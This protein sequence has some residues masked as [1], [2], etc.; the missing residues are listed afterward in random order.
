MKKLFVIWKRNVPLKGRNII[1]R[2]NQG[3][4]KT[5]KIVKITVHSW[6]KNKNY[7]NW[8]DRNTIIAHFVQLKRSGGLSTETKEKQCYSRSNEKQ[9]Y[10]ASTEYEH[11]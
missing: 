3:L 11:K 10:P 4:T 1:L 6:S 9:N 2:D 7:L 5:D 8:P